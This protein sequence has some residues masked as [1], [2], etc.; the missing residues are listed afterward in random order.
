ML[1]GY[2]IIKVSLYGEQ[3]I[4]LVFHQPQVGHDVVLSD[5]CR[6][7]QCAPY[8]WAVPLHFREDAVHACERGQ[9]WEPRTHLDRNDVV[10]IM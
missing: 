1:T 3:L 10:Q 5:P 4:G 6:R 9:P 7:A 8:R 2:F